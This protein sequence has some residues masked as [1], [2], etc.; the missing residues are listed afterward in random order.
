MSY[1]VS[2]NLAIHRHQL[3]SQIHMDV[4]EIRAILQQL[5]D[6]RRAEVSRRFF[7]T[8]PGE[9]GEGDIFLGISVP[10][11]RELAKECPDLVTEQA[12]QLLHSA[13]HE[14]RLLALLLLVRLYAKGTEAEKKRIYALYLNNT[15]WIN[16]WDLVDASAPHIIGAYLRH[17]SKQPLYRLARSPLLWERRISIIATF[18]FI[19][20][21]EFAETLEIARMLLDDRED[22]IHKATGW[23]LRE[24]GKRH[25]PSEE[26][27][28]HK[29][30]HRMP[31]TMLRYAIEKFPEAKR[32][33]FLS[34]L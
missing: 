14:E 6:R 5:G 34:P 19:R 28:L 21:N 15:R 7:K 3:P 23:M 4:D 17:R 33:K 27:F 16:N 1:A 13:I 30:C 11:L 9:Y 29:Y 12:E 22:L 18:H 25:L 2:S 10:E 31:R 24:V 26:E 8:G 20:H 32:K